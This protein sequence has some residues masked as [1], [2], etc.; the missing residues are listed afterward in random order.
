[1]NSLD[2]EQIRVLHL[3][4]TAPAQLDEQ[5]RGGLVVPRQL[6]EFGYIRRDPRGALALT[7]EG[8]RRLF[9]SKC[10]DV[11]RALA[12][13]AAPTSDRGTVQWLQSSGFIAAPEQT[14]PHAAVPSI[15]RRGR[16]W[17]ESFE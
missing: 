3:L 14:S 5:V 4:S 17:L 7:K 10:L 8:E 1:M 9:H 12:D 15:T 2:Q 16:L 11:L 6:F 13:G